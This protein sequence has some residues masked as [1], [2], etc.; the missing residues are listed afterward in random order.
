M[1]VC[2]YC[3]QVVLDTENDVQASE[4]CRCYEAE[5]RRKL[6]HAA[7]DAREMVRDLFG[8]GAAA[9]GLTAISEHAIDAL[10]ACLDLLGRGDVNKC[11][12]SIPGICQ[13]RMTVSGNAIVVERSEGRKIQSVAGEK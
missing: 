1:G 9:R 12:I 6:R 4:E 2:K 3:G 8:E 13:I 5:R 11:T 7:L 10:Y